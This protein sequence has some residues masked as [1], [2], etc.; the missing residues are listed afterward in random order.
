MKWNGKVGLLLGAFVVCFTSRSI[1]AAEIAGSFTLHSETKWG[2][3]VLAPGD[4]T[5]TLDKAT[6]NGRIEIRRG[7]KGVAAVQAQGLSNT[8][9]AGTSSM[10]I[11]GSRVQSLYLA[12]LG[13]TYKYQ[14]HKERKE[15][16]ARN[17]SVPGVTVSVAT[18]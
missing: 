16:L 2:V 18:K 11:V 1:N 5:F 3:A 4:Y 7:K 10:E 14:E 15:M 13:I 9:P 17:S 8:S 6:L 12:P